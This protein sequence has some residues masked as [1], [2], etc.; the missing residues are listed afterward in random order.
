MRGGLGLH[1]GQHVLAGLD[2]EGN[3]GVPEA[4]TYYLDGDI[5]LDEQRPVDL[6]MCAMYP[7]MSFLLRRVPTV[8][9]GG[10]IG[11]T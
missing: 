7:S 2:G 8:E 10:T 1:A 5:L 11:R 3:V 9:L 6:A 4:L